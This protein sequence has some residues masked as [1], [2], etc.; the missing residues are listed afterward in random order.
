MSTDDLRLFLEERLRAMDPNIRIDQGSPAASQV[1]EPT[2]RRFSPDPFEVDLERLIKTRLSQ[3]YPQLATDEGSAIVDLLIKPAL[4]LLEPFRRE[5]KAIA[6]NQSLADPD[7]LNADEADAILANTW[8][9]RNAGDFSRVKVRIYFQNPLT[10]N[11]GS[12][13]VVYT[14]SGLRFLPVAPQSI[15]SEAMLFNQDGDLFYFDVDYVAEA[16]GDKYNIDASMVIGVTGLASASRVRNLSK[17]EGGINEETTVE[18][19]SRGETSTGERSLTTLPGIISRLFEQFPSLNLLNVIGFNDA[20]M[21]RDVIVG[22]S[23]GDSVMYGVGSTA[24]DGDVDGYTPYLDAVGSDFT[25]QFGPVGTDLSSYTVVLWWDPG[26]GYEPHDFQLGQV[27]GAT[28]VSI[29]SKYTYNDRLPDSLVSCIWQIRT[30]GTIT[31]S[32]IPGGILFPDTNGVT[33]DVPNNTIHIGGCTDFYV[34]GGTNAE[35]SVAM[36]IIADRDVIARGLI[37]QTYGSTFSRRVDL[38]ITQVQYDRIIAGE[39]YIRIIGAGTPITPDI[40]SYR[41]VEK[42]GYTTVGRV[43]IES[44]LTGDC[45]GVNVEIVDDID[46]ELLNPKEVRVEAADLR[47]Y[48]GLDQVDNAGTTDYNSYDVAID[49]YLTILDG[50]NAGTYKITAV[51]ANQLTLDVAL[52]Y[53]ESP[54]SYRVTRSLGS[55]LELPLLRIRSVELLD[56]NLKP[57]GEFVPYRRPVDIRSKQFSNIGREPKAGTS[58]VITSDT[59][60]STTGSPIL[61]SSK[62][63]LD[64]YRLGLR[65]GDIVNILTSDNQ[66]FYTVEWVGGDPDPGNP[67]TDSWKIQVSENLKW[68][69]SGMRYVVGEP[70]IG[71]FRL[72]FLEPCTFQADSENTL[73]SVVLEDGTVKRFRPDPAIWSQYLPTEDTIP[74]ARMNGAPGTD[75]IYLYAVGGTPIVETWDYGA[76]IGDRVE[77]TYC[78]LVG[79]FDIKGAGGVL[80]LNGK[81][82]KI[83]LG[84][85]AETVTFTSTGAASID[86][87]ISQINTQLS[88]AVATKYEPT[89]AEAYLVLRSDSTITLMDNSALGANDAT[90]D[91]FGVDRT[92]FQPW[93]TT[94]AWQGVAGEGTNNESH[95]KGYWYVTGINPW[96][97]YTLNLED[98]DGNPFQSA[99]TVVQAIGHYVKISHSGV[100][101]LSSTAMNENRDDLGMYYFDVECVS[102][103]YGNEWNIEPDLVGTMS[104][105]YSEGWDVTV[106]DSRMSFSMSEKPWLNISPRFLLVGNTDDIINY[107]DLIEDNIQVNY[108]QPT[109]VSAIHSFVRDQQERVVCESPLVR[110]LFPI[111]VRTSIEYID[112][113]SETEIRKDISELIASILPEKQLESSDV[114]TTITSTGATKVV[115]PVTL[116]GVKHNKDRTI[117]V[118]RS[119]DSISSERLHAL[120]ADD[121]GTTV[122]G[123]SYIILSR[124]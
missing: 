50:D 14:A 64:F 118:E 85:G 12:S 60:S 51:A 74:T 114:L 47:A 78:P 22:G 95:M 42:V 59:M 26:A 124:T 77:I 7:V 90:N 73:L 66:G 103:G 17:A 70:S 8:V 54:L 21:E 9:R 39:T 87:I 29:N 93:L 36:R 23:I 109:I 68:T 48:A 32:D 111:F 91:I 2:I 116:V 83:N 19:I 52:S 46:I 43:Y 123:S 15:T 61:T 105:Y 115:M 81:S 53:T 80:G 120:Q 82:I 110:S 84:L 69:A 11:I 30:S 100:Q 76:K 63:S 16:P 41:V 27:E 18:V 10:V 44:S 122:E 104:G 108:E 24:D 79:D 33:L 75:Y 28:R 98:I 121:D 3:E 94:A 112:G 99:Y 25:A 72:Y 96:G 20:E 113:A 117:V 88:K 97:T 37:A 86:D 34:Q 58:V 4:V 5:I 1:I 55:A 40:G 101:R 106:E 65:S 119:E 13:N 89:P 38:S 31:L 102:E 92:V 71:S 107:T 57:R 67:L 45:T 62:T 56:S 6:R 49:D 35:K